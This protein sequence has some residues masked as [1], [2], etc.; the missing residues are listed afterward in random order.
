MEIK[1]RRKGK[2]VVLNLS[3]RIDVNSA[4]FIE[5][6]GGCLRNGYRDIICNFEGVE[7]IEY[8]GLSVIVIAYKSVLN[9]K[10]R[11]VFIN[12][13]AHL[14]EL[15]SVAGIDKSIDIFVSEEAAL[16]SFKE[17]RIIEKIKKLPLRRRFKRLPIDIHV[18]IKPKYSKG[19]ICSKVELL[20]L[21]AIGAYI[22]GCKKLKLGDEVIL[23][24]K[25]PRKKSKTLELDARVVWLSDKKV[26]QHIHP[27]IGV[28]F[29]NIS[30]TKQKELLAFIEKN[31]SFI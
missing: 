30:G 15:L 9:K 13:P 23:R 26:Q 21:S 6:V 7:F 24:L 1:A 3:G 31:L 16:H 18:E 22:Y 14:R 4:N 8:M 11:I 2:A 27:G 19:A 20:N 28:E 5:A 12:V 25:L 17:D 10:G 29:H